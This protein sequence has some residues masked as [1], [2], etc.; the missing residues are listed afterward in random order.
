MADP[1]MNRLWYGISVDPVEII[2]FRAKQ[3]APVPTILNQ[4]HWITGS[5]S[6]PII[7]TQNRQIMIFLSNLW[8]QAY[9]KART[10]CVAQ[11]AANHVRAWF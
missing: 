9:S 7:L 1:L 6:L 11:I 2:L 8:I 3:P 5:G 4:I 10:N